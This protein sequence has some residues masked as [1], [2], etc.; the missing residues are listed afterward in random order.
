MCDGGERLIL[1]R[2]RP[3]EY[4]AEAALWS[5]SYHCDA[6]AARPVRLLEIPAAACRAAAC[7]TSRGLR[8]RFGSRP[9]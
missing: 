1:H 9:Y 7:G 8:N 4:F 5:G 6:V 3:G 2:A